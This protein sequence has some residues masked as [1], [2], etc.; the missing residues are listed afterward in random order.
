M[1]P[2]LAE[3][4]AAVSVENIQ[5]LIYDRKEEFEEIHFLMFLSQEQIESLDFS[6]LNDTQISSMFPTFREEYLA[7]A[8]ERY[9]WTSVEQREHMDGSLKGQLEADEI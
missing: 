9:Q 3:K 8:K 7:L 1:L 4:M 2:A 5:H 6:R